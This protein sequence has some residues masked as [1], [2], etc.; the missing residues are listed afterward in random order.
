[1]LRCGGD[2]RTCG[3]EGAFHIKNRVVEPV[4]F[5]E[6][7]EGNIGHIVGKRGVDL[8]RMRGR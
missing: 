3:C 8:G 4:K 7:S 6:C 5:V 1:M 2:K